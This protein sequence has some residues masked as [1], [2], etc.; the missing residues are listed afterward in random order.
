MS[1]SSE[2][3]P[4]SIMCWAVI[5]TS[6]WLEV[7]MSNS[8]AS[9]ASDYLD[10]F[11]ASL[12][13][14]SSTYL[15]FWIFL[16]Q[17]CQHILYFGFLHNFS[18]PRL[19]TCLIFWIFAQFFSTKVINMSYILDFCLQ[20]DKRRACQAAPAL[21]LQTN[22]KNK[23]ILKV[24]PWLSFCIAYFPFATA[25]AFFVSLIVCTHF[26]CLALNFGLI[27]VFGDAFC[28]FLRTL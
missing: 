6:L 23:L 24:P 8:R 1:D 19:S 5:L 2:G 3:V 25:L 27:H 20:A 15:I 12:P 4:R 9:L 16:R 17:G 28:I 7:S 10:N 26:P 13:P 11:Y 18:A 14:R 21:I 22:A